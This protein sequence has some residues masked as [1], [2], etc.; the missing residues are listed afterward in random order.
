MLS[1]IST[2]VVTCLILVFALMNR[3]MADVNL[4]P[5]SLE[6]KAPLYLMIIITVFLGFLL[7]AIV[8]WLKSLKYRRQARTLA[9]YVDK[10][11]AQLTTIKDA[12]PETENEKTEEE[13]I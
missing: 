12:L 2:V 7:G 4:W 1:W 11:E 8:M 6:M 5:F 10:L 3:Q 13:K 9:K